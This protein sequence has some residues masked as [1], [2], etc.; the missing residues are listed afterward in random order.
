MVAVFEEEKKVCC[1]TVV[2]SV[3]GS[4]GWMIGKRREKWVDG[5]QPGR[6]LPN[7]IATNVKKSRRCQQTSPNVIGASFDGARKLNIDIP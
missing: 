2:G 6:R 4:E 5:H 7:S 1:A 3:V